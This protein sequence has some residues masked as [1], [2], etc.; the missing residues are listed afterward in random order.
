MGIVDT[1]QQALQE[2]GPWALV[3]LFGASLIEYVFPPFPGDSVVVLGAFYAARGVLPLPGVF[4]A[5]TF[6]SVAGAAIDYAIGMRLRKATERLPSDGSDP[7]RTRRLARMRRIEAADERHGDLYILANRFL[8]GIRGFFF[9][10]AGM[11]AIPRRR[12]LVL[13]G[14]SAAV[15]NA[16]LL[17]A[18][19]AV[20]ENLDHLEKLFRTYSL[21]AWGA[22]GAVA[23][24]LVLRWVVGRLRG[25]SD[26]GA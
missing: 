5:V 20:G 11:A 22:I 19:W 7:R 12:V 21:L 9:V 17:A 16:L 2:A 4:A 15:W 25:S 18:G 6:G 23:A 13:G 8:P 1:L 10:A 24:L 26:G 14:I 3:I